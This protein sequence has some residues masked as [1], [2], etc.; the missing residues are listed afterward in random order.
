MRRTSASISIAVCSLYSLLESA[1][2]R[3][4]KTSPSCLPK[5][6]G[7]NFSDMPQSQTMR[8]AMSV[9][10]WMSFEAPV[11]S[12]PKITSSAM[13]PPTR[14][15]RDLVD[16]IV[17]LGEPTDQRVPRLV[18]GGVPLLLVADDHRAALGAHE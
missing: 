18:V 8:R 5:C 17:V 3:P 12:C 7:P 14:D 11:V 1:K 10:C 13:R 2:S 16:R 6:S 15:D 9:A 4:R